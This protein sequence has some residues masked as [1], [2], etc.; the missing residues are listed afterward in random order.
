MLGK[1]SQVPWGQ[2]DSPGCPAALQRRRASSKRL[3]ETLESR[4]VPGRR[5][6]NGRPHSLFPVAML[7][8]ESTGS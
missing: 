4:R 1:L 5:M 8:M 3:K 2:R 6:K 7:L